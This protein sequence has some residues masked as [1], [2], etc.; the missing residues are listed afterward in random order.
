MPKVVIALTAE[1]VALLREAIDSHIYWQLADPDFR[2]SGYVRELG[3]DDPEM[4]QASR[5]ANALDARLA[6]LERTTGGVSL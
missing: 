2:D 4:V 5:A 1:E 3:S 6:S